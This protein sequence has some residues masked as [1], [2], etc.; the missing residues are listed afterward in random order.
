MCVY[1]IIAGALPLGGF[2]GS[3]PQLLSCA[4]GEEHCYRLS[5][6]PNSGFGVICQGDTSKPKECKDF[7][8]CL[9]DGSSEMEGRLELCANGYW[10]NVCN[11]YRAKYRDAY[12]LW[13]KYAAKLVCRKLGFPTEGTY[14]KS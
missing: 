11:D 12:S 2:S 9:V 6:Y 5:C 8:V 4:S 1:F 13:T 3:Y 7:D 10:S 14:P